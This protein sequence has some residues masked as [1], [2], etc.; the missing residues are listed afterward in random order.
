MPNRRK[1]NKN[2][3]GKKPV[4]VVIEKPKAKMKSGLAMY[5]ESKQ[6]KNTP[7]ANYNG[8]MLAPNKNMKFGGTAA[9]RVASGAGGKVKQI[10]MQL[11]APMNFPSLRWADIYSSN[12]TATCTPFNF[13]PAPFMNFQPDVISSNV[14]NYVTAGNS[15]VAVFRSPARSLIYLDPNAASNACTYVGYFSS[16]TLPTLALPI[17]ADYDSVLPLVYL[18]ILSGQTYKPH[19]AV[20]YCGT[21]DSQPGFWIDGSLAHPAGIS[22][23]FADIINA[24][25]DNYRLEGNSWVNGTPLAFNASTAG[26]NVVIPGYYSFRLR[27]IG[28]NPAT[29]LQLFSYANSGS[30]IMCHLPANVTVGNEALMSDIRTLTASIC[31]TNE[32]SDLYRSGM[33]VGAQIPGNEAWWSFA[34]GNPLKN[35]SGQNK[36]NSGRLLLDKGIYGFLKITNAEDV[37][38]ESTF[39]VSMVAGTPQFVGVEFA[40]IPKRDYL[41]IGMETAS[42]GGSYP[43]GDLYLTAA[44]ALEYRTNSQLIEQELTNYTTAETIVAVETLRRMPQ[45]HENPL[46]LSDMLQFA[47]QAGKKIV[48]GIVNYGP[49]ALA[50]AA[51][52]APLLL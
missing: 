24:E 43:G 19:G 45:W 28:T 25:I 37:N 21:H 31:V 46:H 48:N 33:A 5:L 30:Q 3:K 1:Q 12:P 34:Q 49:S 29:T 13:L 38:F 16:N 42:V 40:L 52:L 17:S 26:F 20:L 41:F 39:N 23:Q 35:L 11:S 9:A 32:A 50:L 18:G 44:W 15:F 27:M 14:N 6:S 7:K 10:I 51:K 8:R 2:I 36:S 47:Q 22:F 4:V